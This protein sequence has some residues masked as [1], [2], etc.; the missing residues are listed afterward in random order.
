[1]FQLTTEL[2]QDCF[3]KVDALMKETF[4][5]EYTTPTFAKI[6]LSC[7]HYYW[8]QIRAIDRESSVY[9]LNISRQCERFETY[10]SGYKQF[11]NGLIHEFIHTLPGAWNHGA[12]FLR[13]CT[14]FMEKHPRYNITVKDNGGEHYVPEVRV[15]KYKYFVRCNC[16][17]TVYKYQRLC[18]VVRYPWMY[19]CSKCN[20]NNF[21]VENKCA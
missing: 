7:A 17:G 11:M 5:N 9:Q 8:M 10:E 16:C 14:R 3:K 19:R 12:G 6:R 21:T 2:I 13:Y 20:S 18:D 15:K 4:P 1:M